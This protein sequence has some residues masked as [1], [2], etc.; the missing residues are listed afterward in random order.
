M[1]K[2]VKTPWYKYYDGVS[3]HLS[4]PDFSAYKLI[5]YTSS[6]HLNNISYNYYGTKKTYYEFLKQ[7][8]EAARAFKALGV[9]HKDIVAICM[10]NTPEAIIAFYAIN[11]I[12]AISNMIH[13]L[14][15][16]NE[17]KHFLTV[18]KS[19]YVV[20]IDFAFNKINA[21]M[22]DTK[23]KKVITVSVG[24]SMPM[25]MEAIYQATKG[26]KV[27]MDKSDK[28]ITWKDFIKQGYTYTKEIDDDFKSKEVATI[29]YSGGT[30]GTPK[31]VMLT[32][33]NLN[34]L[35]MQ[36]FEA[37]ACLR[38]K[39]KVLAIMP[40]FH[41]FGLGICI[42]TVQYFGG[43]SILLP[44]FSAKTFDKLLKKYKPNII[45][46]VPTLYEA[47]LKN[48]NLDGY[49]LSF[50]KCVISGGDS[51]S[52]ELKKKIDKFLHEHNANIQVRE[53]YGLTECV[54]GSCLTPMEYYR[55]GSIGIPYPD[56]YYKIVQNGTETELPYGEEGEIVISGP[57]VMQGY[58]RDKKETKQTLRK[59][60]DGLVWLHT[61]DLGI[62]DKDGFVYYKNRLKRLIVSSGYCLYPQYIENIIDAHPAVMMSCVIGI[63][64]PYKVEVAK[65]FIVLKDKTVDHDAVIESIREHCEK[66]LS[67][68]S[69]PY[70]YEIRDELP[71]TLVGKV[72]YNVLVHE[73]EMKNK[74][75]KFEKTDE[76]LEQVEDE[77]SSEEL[78]DNMK[79]ETKS[80]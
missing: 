76:L 23:V 54:T 22:E 1:N 14:S 59:H 31:G 37:C 80:K 2:K 6:K 68:Y 34:A 46:G 19:N 55:E 16:E 57:T 74:N 79:D 29:L 28:R 58:L 51:L 73:E 44:Q 45:A 49:D 5:E 78:L 77:T 64:H 70:E 7:I 10:P 27:K 21:I 15:G 38:E 60:K 56:T 13:P 41:G 12:G 20:T 69:W 17:I 4:Y 18:S 26:R 39:D 65:A 67:K 11:K 72:A 8:D 62:M 30:T 48:K 61:G 3:E 24:D 33:M 40:V 9:K 50:L 75:R 66:N 63:P 71:K 43:T 42:H 25:Y 32:N 35:A 36:S 53:G 47:L 52:V